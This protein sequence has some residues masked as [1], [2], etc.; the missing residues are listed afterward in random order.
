[1]RGRHAGWLGVAF[2][3]VAIASV[4]IRFYEAVHR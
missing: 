4:A 2:L 3:L 1:M